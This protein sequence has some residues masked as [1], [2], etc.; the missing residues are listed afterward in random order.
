M[1]EVFK[2]DI[3][4]PAKADELKLRLL[5]RFADYKINFDLED[6]DRIMRIESNEIK[7]EQVI[8]ELRE[9][10]FWCEVLDC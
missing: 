7:K 4:D 6:C 3:T 10:G 5:K 2:T 8:A 1:V 9:Q